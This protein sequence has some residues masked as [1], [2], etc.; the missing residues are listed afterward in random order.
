MEVHE[1]S[2]DAKKNKEAIMNNLIKLG[3]D[4]HFELGELYG[5][6]K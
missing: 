2:N 1:D 5:C 3:F 4:V 6:R